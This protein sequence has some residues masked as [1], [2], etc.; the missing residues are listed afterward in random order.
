MVRHLDSAEKLLADLS[1]ERRAAI[2]EEH[3]LE[4]MTPKS[5]QSLGILLEELERVKEQG[6]AYSFEE[7]VIGLGC[8]A[9]PIFD[10]AGEMVAALSITTDIYRF[11]RHLDEYREAIVRTA[12]RVSR[13]L[14]HMAYKD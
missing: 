11:E 10:F 8:V 9:A 1:E 3:G 4:P 13:R 7:S 2:I 12:E 14:G 6:H 5:I